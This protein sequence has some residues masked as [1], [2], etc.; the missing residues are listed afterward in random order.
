MKA[1]FD[2]EKPIAEIEEMIEKLKKLS[3]DHDS[4]YEKELSDLEEK[5]RRR[6]E[7]VYSNLTPWQNFLNMILVIPI[8]VALG[9]LSDITAI[10]LSKKPGEA[11]AS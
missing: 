9:W 5:C 10:W 2:F 3:K 1:D 8:G 4:Q 6:K 7:E 11:E